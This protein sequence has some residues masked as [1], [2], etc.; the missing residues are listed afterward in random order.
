MITRR[1]FMFGGALLT[2]AATMADAEALAEFLDWTKRKPAFF[3]PKKP[4]LIYEPTMEMYRVMETR[5]GYPT[6]LQLLPEIYNPERL[7]WYGDKPVIEYSPIGGY[8]LRGQGH[9]FLRPGDLVTSA[10][11]SKVPLR[12]EVQRRDNADIQAAIRRALEGEPDHCGWVDSV[13]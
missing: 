9:G 7:G 3:I 8:P 10:D 6:V 1:Q 13:A 2:T 4:A 5:D 11:L 12:S